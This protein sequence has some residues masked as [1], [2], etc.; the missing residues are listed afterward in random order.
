MDNVMKSEKR[1]QPPFEC[2]LVIQLE[3]ERQEM[4]VRINGSFLDDVPQGISQRETLPQ[5]QVG[6]DQSGRSTHAHDAMHQHFPCRA[7]WRNVK[8]N[9]ENVQKTINVLIHCTIFVLQGS[10][11]EVNCRFKVLTE[12]EAV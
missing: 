6:Q 1:T 4:L 8:G 2:Q 9:R 12:V 7:G 3:E 10:M 5:H 11:H